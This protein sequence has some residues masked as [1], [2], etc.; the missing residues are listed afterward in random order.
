MSFE[1]NQDEKPATQVKPLTEYKT[2]SKWKPFKEGAIAYFNSVK[3]FH[4][5]PLAYV[6]RDQENPDLNAAYQTEHHRLI[7]ITPLVGIEFE[8]DNS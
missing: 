1:N 7:S 4:N 6:I 5:I 3:G 2:G 8:E